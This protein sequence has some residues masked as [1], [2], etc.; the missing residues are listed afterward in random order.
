M[1]N[2][3]KE[4]KCPNCGAAMI[5]GHT[6]VEGERSRLRWYP[7]LNAPSNKDII[8]ISFTKGSKDTGIQF[9]S[10]SLRQAFRPSWYCENCKMLA[11]DTKTVL[12]KEN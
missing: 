1:T 8:K 9:G 6:P 5:L 2:I 11:I 7:G 10:W 3:N 12:Y 4:L